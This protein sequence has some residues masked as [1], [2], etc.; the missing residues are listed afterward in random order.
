MVTSDPSPT[1]H[2]FEGIPRRPE[3]EDLSVNPSPFSQLLSSQCTAAASWSPTQLPPCVP[4]DCLSLP[5]APPQH[6][7]SD[8]DNHTISYGHS[9]RRGLWYLALSE[10]A[11]LASSGL[12]K[13][14][15]G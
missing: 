8:W 11:P 12:A 13:L 2:V 1:G 14:C 3:E 5:P 10:T 4:Y 7:S 9:V 6:V 15:M